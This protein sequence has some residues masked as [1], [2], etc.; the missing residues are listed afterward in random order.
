MAEASPLAIRSQ[1]PE[2]PFA[3]MIGIGSAPRRRP[4]GLPKTVARLP[5]ASEV[6]SLKVSDIDSKR[7]V[8]RV[9]EGNDCYVTRSPHLLDGVHPKP[10]TQA[11]VAA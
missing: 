9:E 7:M 11:A 10:S 4:F 5:R 3:P 1:A 8:F 6:I 2:R